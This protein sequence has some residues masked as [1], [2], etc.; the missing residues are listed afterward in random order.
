MGKALFSLIAGIF[1]GAFIFEIYK[2][3]KSKWEFTRMLEGAIEK[4]ATDIFAHSITKN[5]EQFE[6]D[7]KQ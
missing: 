7:F 2:R 4:E 5:E 1:V 3:S 6:S